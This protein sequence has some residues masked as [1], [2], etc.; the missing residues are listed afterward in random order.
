MNKIINNFLLKVDK[1]MPE[2]H[3]RQPGFTYSA[4]SSFTKKGILKKE[5]KNLKN[6]EIHEIYSKTN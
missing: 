1:F 4:C 5:W 2:M 6:Q 3:L